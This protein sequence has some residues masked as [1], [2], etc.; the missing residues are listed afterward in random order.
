M[1]K[2]CV[3][4]WW[5][6]G[7]VMKNRMHFV[8]HVHKHRAGTSKEGL[9]VRGER[10]GGCPLLLI[11]EEQK[12]K[13]GVRADSSSQQDTF[14]ETPRRDCVCARTRES[15]RSLPTACGPRHHT[16][17]TN[18][19]VVRCCSKGSRRED[20]PHNPQR[21]HRCPTNEQLA[22]NATRDGGHKLRQLH[23]CCKDCTRSLLKRIVQCC[24]VTA[25]MPPSTPR[26]AAPR[27]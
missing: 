6:C 10:R 11:L 2:S 3:R 9:K 24:S 19:A 14:F 21:T 5:S 13:S 12:H 4:P 8:C 20:K 22:N 16:H 17:G 26:S 27:P 7:N 18:G 15:T 23:T 25:M 1:P